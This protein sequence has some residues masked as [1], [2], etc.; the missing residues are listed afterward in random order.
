MT[1]AT[2]ERPLAKMSRAEVERAIAQQIPEIQGH[3]DL[4]GFAYVKIT[5]TSA[6]DCFAADLTSQVLKGEEPASGPMTNAEIA[7]VWWKVPAREKWGR[8]K[9]AHGGR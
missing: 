5:R 7:K 4:E 2:N 1:N 8:V 9:A 6:D 3:L